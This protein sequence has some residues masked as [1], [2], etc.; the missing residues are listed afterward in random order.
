[1]S[2]VQPMVS[3]G[4]EEGR[5]QEDEQGEMEADVFVNDDIY[6]LVVVAAFGG[7]ELNLS[8]DFRRTLHPVVLWI[9]ACALFCVQ[10]QSLMLL[11][12]DMDVD[13]EV[14]EKGEDMLISLKLLMISVLQLMLFKELMG[15][16][17]LLAFIINPTTW[18]DVKRPN[19]VGAK[20]LAYLAFSPSFLFPLCLL[21]VFFKLFIAYIVC[22]DSV[23]LVLEC[24]TV[25]DA[26]FNCLAITFIA[27]L[28][29]TAWDVTSA[30][31]NFEKKKDWVF[32]LFDSEKQKV[33]VESRRECWRTVVEDWLRCLRRGKGGRKAEL[34]LTLCFMTFVYMRQ[35]FVILFALETNKLPM[36]RDLCTEWRIMNGASSSSNFMSQALGVMFKAISFQS[37]QK[38]LDHLVKHK[39]DHDCD[40]D[41]KYRRMLPS[42]MM[43]QVQQ[44]PFE[45]CVVLGLICGVL[46]LPQLLMAMLTQSEGC[47]KCIYGQ[48]YRAVSIQD[49]ETDEQ[50]EIQ[51]LKKELSNLQ[52]RLGVLESKR[53]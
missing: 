51:S 34:A 25:K 22:I 26:I 43:Y 6:D 44:N 11:R 50:K 48:D 39:L 9:F 1:M 12:L 33:M 16:A 46:I 2:A 17:R 8:G 38:Y 24:R 20:S 37:S 28:D 10:L 52:R 3:A 18:T 13:Q 30:L 29:E 41:G 53:Q 49:G 23:S 7:I 27:D 14:K 21:A 5:K 4:E 47:Q 32:T 45:C 35:L 36:A 31:F 15:S 42:D 40:V 19:A